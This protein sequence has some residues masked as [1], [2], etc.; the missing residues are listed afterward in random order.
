MAG[1]AFFALVS[2][3]AEID[4]LSLLRKQQV[5]KNDPADDQSA[6]KADQKEN[7]P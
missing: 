6:D 3:M 2:Y 7:H 1:I 5:R 4:R